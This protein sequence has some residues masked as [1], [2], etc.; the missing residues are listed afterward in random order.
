MTV[1]ADRTAKRRTRTWMAAVST[2]L[3]VAATGLVTTAP[4][5]AA[6]APV[7]YVPVGDSYS[8]GQGL[9]STFQGCEIDDRA[10]PF[11]VV[12]PGQ[13]AP[14][15][16]NGIVSQRACSGATSAQV[17]AQVSGVPA[18]TDLITVTVGANDLA[19]TDV[20]TQCFLGDCTARANG[21][22]TDTILPGVEAVLARARAS[23]ATVV[24]NTYPNLF[25]RL[26][27]DSRVTAAEQTAGSSL[28]RRLNASLRTA[29]SR[30]G[31]HVAD[32]EV[33]FAGH[34]PCG[35]S[36]CPGAWVNGLVVT[37]FINVKAESFH[38]NAD[39][40]QATAAM[41]SQLL[42]SWTGPR[43]VDTLLPLNP[44]PIPIR[45]AAIV[46]AA[47]SCRTGGTFRPLDLV[48]VTSPPVFAAGT[49]VTL[50][51]STDTGYRYKPP[52]ATAT[53]AGRL[54]TAFVLAGGATG[55]SFK[56]EAEGQSMHGTWTYLLAQ[57]GLD[58]G[59]SPCDLVPPA[60]QI[61]SPVGSPSY[62]LN[63]TV[64]VGFGCT[65]DRR[66]SSC[67]SNAVAAGRLNTA[68]PGQ[69]SFVV[70]ARDWAGN[71]TTASSTYTV[72]YV[73]LDRSPTWTPADPPLVV[74]RTQSVVVRFR[75]V[76]ANGIGVVDPAAVLTPEVLTGSCRSGTPSP[77]KVNRPAPASDGGVWFTVPTGASGNCTSVRIPLADG[78]AQ[79]W[80]FQ[81]L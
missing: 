54:D 76:D 66:L 70:T 61:T 65:D 22:D 17:L 57:Q 23:G 52:A 11:S 28:M 15:R 18:G 78:T 5:Q 40:E 39:G 29:A 58:A 45:G 19:L 31:V 75:I 44:A 55:S 25:A 46:T 38:L 35:S 37:N 36:P 32:A 4:A 68:T 72:R 42:A 62:L 63:S 74:S 64:T 77:V 21:I 26:F 20:I 51:L 27:G 3:V 12:A 60:A 79:S 1:R 14:I 33:A 71:A 24:M 81:W 10:W 13:V 50:S 53:S 49:V 48:R 80:A 8:S 34:E 56:L 2:A 73:T 7:F 16:S 69:N 67:T 41:V 6:P 43:T 9:R 30:A 59:L 47:E